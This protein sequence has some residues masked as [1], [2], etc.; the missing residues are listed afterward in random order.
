MRHFGKPKCIWCWIA[1][2]YTLR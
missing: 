2:S 1:S